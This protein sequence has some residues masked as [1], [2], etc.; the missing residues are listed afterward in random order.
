MPFVRPTP[1]LLETRVSSLTPASIKPWISATGDPGSPNPLTKMVEP[2]PIPASA[3]AMLG[4]SLLI[5]PHRSPETIIFMSGK[6]FRVPSSIVFDR[7]HETPSQR[8]DIRLIHQGEMLARHRHDGA[9]ARGQFGPK[10]FRRPIGA[11]LGLKI[12]DVP[13]ITSRNIIPA[14]CSP[15]GLVEK[16]I[17]L[18]R[19]QR[20]RFPKLRFA[21]ASQPAMQVAKLFFLFQ[22]PERMGAR[23]Q[24]AIHVPEYDVNKGDPDSPVQPFAPGK[25]LHQPFRKKSG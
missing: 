5:I 24:R 25:A 16:K 6:K 9:A 14:Y 21:F 1:P 11:L 4:T 19:V 17:P 23:P 10:E 12:G 13:R 22:S 3:S 8:L 18:Q 7:R 20:R 2:L 15:L